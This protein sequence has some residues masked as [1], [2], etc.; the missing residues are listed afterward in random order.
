MQNG[1]FFLE[2]SY[3]VYK[4]PQT[5]CSRNEKYHLHSDV[6]ALEFVLLLQ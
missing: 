3:F 1:S 5:I 4:T 6:V 2:K